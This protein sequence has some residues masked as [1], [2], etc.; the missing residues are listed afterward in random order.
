MLT[1]AIL[2]AAGILLGVGTALQNYTLLS[3]GLQ[4]YILVFRRAFGMF[5]YGR[6]MRCFYS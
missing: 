6:K 5:S 3:A 1:V 2:P 4:G